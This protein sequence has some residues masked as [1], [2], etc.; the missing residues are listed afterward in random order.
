MGL[1]ISGLGSSGSLYNNN[2]GTPSDDDSEGGFGSELSSQIGKTF[3]AQLHQAQDKMTTANQINSQYTAPGVTDPSEPVATGLEA[4]TESFR[5]ILSDP[6]IVK[7][8]NI[9][10]DQLDRLNKLDSNNL[11]IEKA[12]KKNVASLR[13]SFTRQ[14]NNGVPDNGLIQNL[15]QEFLTLKQ[16]GKNKVLTNIYSLSEILSADQLS[17]LLKVAKER[18]QS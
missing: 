11:D 13:E 15:Q 7:E 1:S 2:I 18:Q 6:K 4:L 14:L 3:E 9:S 10:S 16:K 12:I 5:D 8:L 17:G